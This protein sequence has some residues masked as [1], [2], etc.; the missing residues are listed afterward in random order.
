M[1]IFPEVQLQQ[2]KQGNRTSG[3]MTME[4]QRIFN[5]VE[6]LELQKMEVMVKNSYYDYLKKYLSES[7]NLDQV[8]I[9]TSLGITDPVLTSLISKIIDLQLDVKLFFDREKTTNP[10]MTNKINRLTELKREVV[11][12]IDGLR[13]TDKIKLDFLNTQIIAVEKQIGYLPLAERQLI[14]IQRNY[15]LLENLYVFLMQKMSEA[16]ISKASNTSDIILVNPP[17]ISGGP[18]SPKVPQNILI[19]VLTGLGLPLIIF[20]ILEVLDT[21]VQSREDIEKVT[22]IPFIGGVGHKQGELNLEVL[23]SPKSSIAESFRALRSNL[24]YFVSKNEK[25]V[26]LITSSI[27]GR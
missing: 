17:M 11:E 5:K 19:G 26:F 12:S 18:I 1:V 4:A 13:S 23:K 2:F 27:S 25:A 8:I 20:I 16:E 3:N 7:K 10:L 9:P 22:R 14:S 24:N 15:S 6:S 21:R